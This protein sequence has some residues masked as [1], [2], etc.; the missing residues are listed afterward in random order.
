MD[1]RWGDTGHV[2]GITDLSEEDMRWRWEGLG[3]DKSINLSRYIDV[4]KLISASAI[5][6]RTLVHKGNW[7]IGLCF[8]RAFL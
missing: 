3:R 4:R 6:W 7:E 2:V 5:G 1:S 8:I